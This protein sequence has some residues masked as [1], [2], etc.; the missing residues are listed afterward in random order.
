MGA[1][2]DVLLTVPGSELHKVVQNQQHLLA[3]GVFSVA[4]TGT[5]TPQECVEAAV[6]DVVWPLGKHLPVLKAADTIYSFALEH[7]RAEYLIVV[8]PQGE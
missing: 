3:Q 4:I 5:G 8:L 1:T 2:S 7:T 6:G